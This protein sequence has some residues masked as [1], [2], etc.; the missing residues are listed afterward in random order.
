MSSINNIAPAQS[1]ITTLRTTMSAVDLALAGATVT[2]DAGSFTYGE[3][4]LATRAGL[5][6]TGIRFYW[7]GGLGALSVK[8][9]LWNPAGTRL[10]SA[11]VAVN[12]AGEYTGLFA[13]PQTLV[14]FKDYRITTWETSGAYATMITGA[15]L[16]TFT[17]AT[18]VI[19]N[20]NNKDHWPGYFRYQGFYV[21]GDAYPTSGDAVDLTGVLDP[22]FQ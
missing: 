18:L 9:S 1:S 5:V 20:F 7:P 19:G 3:L 10:D 8:V 17:G 22:L 11:T 12:A 21:A 6:M 16:S 4:V 15:N 13:S 2:S 14:A